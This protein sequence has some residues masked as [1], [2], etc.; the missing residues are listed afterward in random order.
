MTRGQR[1]AHRALWMVLFPLLLIAVLRAIL[2]PQEY[3]RQDLPPA[4]APADG[5]RGR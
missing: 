2:V 5:A 3:P 1:R 4:L